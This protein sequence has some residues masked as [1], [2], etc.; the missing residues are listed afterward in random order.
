ML[1]QRNS[2]LDEGCIKLSKKDL[3]LQD[4]DTINHKL[5]LTKL[6]A[7]EKH[8]WLHHPIYKLSSVNFLLKA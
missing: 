5:M 6:K 8:L 4:F 7:A 3:K 2:G 1:E